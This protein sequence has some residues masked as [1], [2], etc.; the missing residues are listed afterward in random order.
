MECPFRAMRAPV[1]ACLRRLWTERLRLGVRMTPGIRYLDRLNSEPGNERER[2]RDGE[3]SPAVSHCD[4]KPPERTRSVLSVSKLL[5]E[6]LISS[7]Q[8]CSV[9]KKWIASVLSDEGS[10][11]DNGQAAL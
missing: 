11:S 6:F 1:R 9:S 8:E 3:A 10:E 7:E 5:G 4:T 2:W